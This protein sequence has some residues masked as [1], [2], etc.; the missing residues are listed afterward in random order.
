MS[1][2]IPSREKARRNP[3]GGPRIQRGLAAVLALLALLVIPASTSFA[4][5]PP[6]R[7]EELTTLSTEVIV[8]RVVDRVSD[9]QEWPYGGRVI[10]TTYRVT[11]G[12][13]LKGETP[14][15]IEVVMPGGK[16]GDTTIHA[17]EC[18]ELAVGQELVLFLKKDVKGLPRYWVFGLERGVF[19]LVGD[20]A[21]PFAHDVAAVAVESLRKRVAGAVEAENDGPR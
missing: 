18:P 11:V 8:G 6:Y 10:M 5:V 19:E 17:S 21:R 2:I 3:P 7:I 1:R 13:R 15:T 20:E 16:V 14:R 9:W 12:E 4:I